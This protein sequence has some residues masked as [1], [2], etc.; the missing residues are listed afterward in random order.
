MVGAV[1]LLPLLARQ[2]VPF[3]LLLSFAKLGQGLVDP[4]VLTPGLEKPVQLLLKRLLRLAQARQSGAGGEEQLAQM[5]LAGADFFPC[6]RQPLMVDAEER[7]ERVLV[8]ASE[9]PCQAIV[10]NDRRIIGTAERVPLAPTADELEFLAVALPQLSPHA[11]LVVGM[12]EVVGRQVRKAEEQV[13][14][15]PQGRGLARLVGA[16]DQVQALLAPRKDPARRR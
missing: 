12:D 3:Q 16:V 5:P 11:K 4:R 7:L 2:L 8:H 15:G 14:Q 9:E 10:G 6:L 1:V 13:R